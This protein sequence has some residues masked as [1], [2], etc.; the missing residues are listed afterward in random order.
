MTAIGLAIV[1]AGY[2]IH[3]INDYR[4]FGTWAK[5]S[6]IVVLFGGTLMLAGICIKIWEVMP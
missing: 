6:A 1:I 3:Y 2:V 5:I 4:I